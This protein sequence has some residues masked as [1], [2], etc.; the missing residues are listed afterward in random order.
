MKDEEIINLYFRRDER[1]I[2]ETD[3]KYG[4]YCKTIAKN[5][6]WSEQDIEECLDDT[7]VKVWN[8]IPPTKPRIFRA[9]IA[10]ITRDLAL[11]M[12]NA[13]KSSKR[14]SGV[15][16]EVLDELAECI[17]DNSDVEHSI[18]EKELESV[19]KDFVNSLDP[20][21]A[22]IFTSRYFYAEEIA[23][24][25]TKFGMTRHNVTVVL[26]RL[27]KKLQGRLVKEGYLAS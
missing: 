10:K 5:I 26:G 18:L 2:E 24:I 21:D 27:R 4:K 13:S 1:A 14:G 17:P 23:N 12:F 7:Y 15:V 6:L 8:R 11:N 3:L 9:F 20:K 22:Y 16:N 25:A 19:I